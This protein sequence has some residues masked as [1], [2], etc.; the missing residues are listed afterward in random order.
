M[1]FADKLDTTATG[2]GVFAV[3]FAAMPAT[4]ANVVAC[5]VANAFD[6]PLKLV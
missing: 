5:T 1:P 4:F 6:N 2:A 3:I